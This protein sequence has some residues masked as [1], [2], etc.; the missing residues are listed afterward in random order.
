[1]LK[2]KIALAPKV[3]LDD[4]EGQHG[5]PGQGGLKGFMIVKAQI[6]LEP[7]DREHGKARYCLTR[8]RLR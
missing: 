5:A 6:A 8:P 4:I 1:M 2:V 7:E 3:R